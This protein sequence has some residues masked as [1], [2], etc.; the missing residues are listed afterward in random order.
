MLVSKIWALLW[1]VKPLK[2]KFAQ[3]GENTSGEETRV[4]L[5]HEIIVVE[6]LSR[7]PAKSLLRF[8]CVC[9]AWRSLVSDSKFIQMHLSRA[10]GR[11]SVN[12]FIASKPNIVEKNCRITTRG[13]DGRCYKKKVTRICKTHMYHIDGDPFN[14]AIEIENPLEPSLHRTQVLGSCNGLICLYTITS[15]CLLNPS[16]REYKLVKLQES[17]NLDD[18][19]TAYGIGYDTVD[20]DYKLVQA[21]KC[22]KFNGNVDY[23][24]V[25]VY[26]LS[27]TTSSIRLGTI[28]YHILN[29]KDS[30]IFLN[31]AIHWIANSNSKGYSV[32]ILSFNM[33][34]KVFR[35]VPRHDDVSEQAAITVGVLRGQL[36]MLSKF[37]TT[38][39]QIWVMSKYG[40][41]NSWTKLCAMEQTVIPSFHMLLRPDIYILDQFLL[42]SFRPLLFLKNGDILMKDG[43]DLLLYDLKEK[44]SRNLELQGIPDWNKTE[45]I[46]THIESLV[47]LKSGTFVGE[48]GQTMKRRT[49]WADIQKLCNKF[50]CIFNDVYEAIFN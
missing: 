12:V 30:G 13:V 40:E 27:D 1:S 18:E 50:I 9:K 34:D 3:E 8:K 15:L 21:V 7:L 24:A 2:H 39:I 35:E 10:I 5:P 29:G 31:E 22:Y 41:P 43:K 44:T 6:I 33:R 25:H 49:R 4:S 36:C 19:R 47:S 17:L 11:D 48:V 14:K 26:S 37:H 32:V 23:S 28:P 42:D 38:Q 45:E 16:T 46:V 20:D